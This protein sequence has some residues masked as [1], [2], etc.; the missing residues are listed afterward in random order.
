VL[1]NQGRQAG[2]VFRKHWKALGPEL[3][4]CR[5]DIERVPENDDIDCEPEGSKLVFL[6]FPIALAQLGAFRCG[7]PPERKVAMSDRWASTLIHRPQTRDSIN[8]VSLI[9][10]Q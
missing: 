10:A 4:K 2:H 6:S 3:L 1:V 7:N 5:I 9:A 8:L